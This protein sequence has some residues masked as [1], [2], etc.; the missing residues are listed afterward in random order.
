MWKLILKNLWSR[1]KNNGLLMAELVVAAVF[2]LLLLDVAIVAL[3]D[4]YCMPHG[5]DTDVLLLGDIGVEGDEEEYLKDCDDDM[6]QER[7]ELMMN[8]LRMMDEVDDVYLTRGEGY[9]C[10]QRIYNYAN[11]FVEADTSKHGVVPYLEYVPGKRFFEISGLRSA[12]G[13]P[14][15]ETLSDCETGSV[16]LTRSLSERLFG[17]ES[18]IGR[19]IGYYFRN[20]DTLMCRVAGVVEDVR[21]SQTERI[22]YVMFLAQPASR[23]TPGYTQLVVRLRNGVD[24]VKFA[25]RLRPSLK[26]E[27][28]VDGMFV[29][30]LTAYSDIISQQ[31]NPDLLISVLLVSVFLFNVCIGVF[32]TF[33]LQ[34]RRRMEEIGVMRSFG[35]SR[36]TVFAMLLGE[37]WTLATMSFVVACLIWL[38]LT[39]TVG[40]AG[41][42][43]TCRLSVGIE[44]YWVSSY[45]WHIAVVAGIVYTIFLL[46]VCIGVFI[47]AYC[48]SRVHP[49]D[50]LRDKQ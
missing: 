39:Q 21:R 45:G 2:S 11:M 32:G 3:Y 19:Q 43:H 17:D 16:V 27:T 23:V 7:A 31:K 46:V 1:R 13:S 35:A 15:V 36:K 34:T 38:H 40:I 28:V 29:K 20:E 8:R 49:V 9:L 50:A 26:K 47:P 42:T 6:L 44:S 24:A 25:D 33:W 18:P 14:S 22:S 4:N 12:E 30:R 37:G 5:Y 10:P 48:A 41:R